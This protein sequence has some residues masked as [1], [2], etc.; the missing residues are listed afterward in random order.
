MENEEVVEVV[1]VVEKKKRTFPDGW[2]AYRRKFLD[3]Y[4]KHLA[5]IMTCPDIVRK[6]SAKNVYDFISSYHDDF[7]RPSAVNQLRTNI[8]MDWANLMVSIYKAKGV[9]VS[10]SIESEFSYALDINIMDCRPESV[11]AVEAREKYAAKELLRLDQVHF[12]RR[13][14]ICRPTYGVKLYPTVE[15]Y[16]ALMEY[17]DKQ[18][19]KL[20]GRKREFEEHHAR[21]KMV[22]EDFAN[23]QQTLMGRGFNVKILTQS[24]IQVYTSTGQYLLTVEMNEHR[25]SKEY[26]FD[27]IPRFEDA[28]GT[29]TAAEMVKYVDRLLSVAGL[30]VEYAAKKDEYEKDIANAKIKFESEVQP[31]QLAIR[32]LLTPVMFSGIIQP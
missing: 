28:L 25:W 11:A 1:E 10:L 19:D 16:R 21:N 2:K 31:L 6:P 3:L 22:F 26:Y 27:V 32:K 7:L 15:S 12:N 29:A 13:R 23:Y 24:K 8:A 18:I 4:K 5:A 9:P 20:P 14:A 30:T 17:I